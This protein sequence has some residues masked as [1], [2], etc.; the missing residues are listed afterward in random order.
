MTNFFPWVGVISLLPDC[1]K[2]IDPD[3]T[4]A[5]NVMRQGGI[6]IFLYFLSTTIYVPVF[7]I[8]FLNFIR[9]AQEFEF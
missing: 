1:Q 2:K 7:K 4:V 6:F 9:T 8:L 3:S 5:E